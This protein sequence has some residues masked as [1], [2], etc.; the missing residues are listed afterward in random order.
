MTPFSVN[1]QPPAVRVPGGWE[2]RRFRLEELRGQGQRELA[3]WIPA[4]PD[5]FLE[6]EESISAHGPSLER[7]ERSDIPF[8]QYLWP[9]ALSMARLVYANDWSA[10]G[11]AGG[12]KVR[13]LELGAGV[14]LVGLAGLAA[15]LHVTFS[16]YQ[17]PAL[18]V[19]A[20][21]ARQNGFSEMEFE[22]QRLDW[23]AP[24]A[25]RFPVILGCE[26]IYEQ[27]IHEPI[28]NVLDQML[29]PGGVAW[30]GDPGR[31]GLPRFIAKAERRGYAVEIQNARGQT[32]PASTFGEFQLLILRHEA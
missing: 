13:A 2:L 18:A 19:A 28:L 29:A 23:N 20:Y 25:W 1:I 21:N 26:V 12:E 16:D 31:S 15:G 27:A 7:P 22:T 17:E 3:F 32:E 11:L 9:A 14:G 30:L 10:E 5:A 8:W 4:E 24:S 6:D